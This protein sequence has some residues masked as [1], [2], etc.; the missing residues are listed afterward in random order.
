M[1]RLSIVAVA[2]L[3]PV[4]VFGEMLIKTIE[5][6]TG[7]RQTVQIDGVFAIPKKLTQVNVFVPGAFTNALTI[8]HARGTN[9]TGTVIVDASAH[10]N[11]TLYVASLTLPVM[12]GDVLFVSNS[13]TRCTTRLVFE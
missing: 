6:R 12:E 9:E 13:V 4:L 8:W 3:V 11:A 2:L 10:S 7:T 5:N 1:K